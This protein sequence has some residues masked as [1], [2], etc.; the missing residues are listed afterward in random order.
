MASILRFFRPRLPTI[1]EDDHVYPLHLL[2]LPKP[3]T[4]FMI[5]TLLFN[6]QLDPDKSGYYEMHAPPAFT[7]T[8]PPVVFTT[9]SSIQTTSISS[10]PILSRMPTTQ[11]LSAPHTDPCN[12][13]AFLPFALRPDFPRAISQVLDKDIPLLSLRV[14]TLSD[15][16]LVGLSWCHLLAD[17]LGLQALLHCWSLVMAGQESRVPPILDPQTD[18]VLQVEQEATKQEKAGLAR[19]PPS[20]IIAAQNLMTSF[21]IILYAIKTIF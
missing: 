8:R 2:D 3:M 4:G 18:M 12:D 16:T 14:T 6:D 1:Q 9:N 7:T 20:E 15:A 21:Q 13:E 17:A 11:T 5:T 10:H 19:L